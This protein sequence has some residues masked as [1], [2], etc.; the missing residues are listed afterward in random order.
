MK[1][2]T[3]L[4]SAGETEE[5]H[6]LCRDMLERFRDHGEEE[7]AQRVAKSCLIHPPLESNLP[8]AVEVARKSVSNP[9]HWVV[10]WGMAVNGLADYRSGDFQGARDWA[11]QALE[12]P[13]LWYVEAQA[14]LILAMSEKQLGHAG[15][16]GTAMDRA[17]EILDANAQDYTD[18]RLERRWHDWLLCKALQQ[19]AEALLAARKQ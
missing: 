8:A 1:A 5:Y 12:D 18:G 13:P 4:I 17:A 15:D 9:D 2:A 14:W 11:R 7:V 3:L 10:R 16:A 19:E 6:Q